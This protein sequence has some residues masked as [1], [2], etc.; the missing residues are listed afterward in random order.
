MF[1]KCFKKST[2]ITINLQK[3][4]LQQKYVWLFEVHGGDGNI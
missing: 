1:A 2:Y 3:A 4:D